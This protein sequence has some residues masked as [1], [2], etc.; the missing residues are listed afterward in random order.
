MPNFEPENL[1]AWSCGKWSHLPQQPIQ[2]FSNDTRTIGQGECFVAIKTDARDGHSFLEQAQQK[3]ASAA[4]VQK[5]NEALDLPQL[6]VGESV[7]AFQ[8]I[9]K[10][11][12][13]GFS[14]SSCRYYWQLRENLNKR[15]SP[16]SFRAG[17]NPCDC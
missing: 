15:S 7:Q 14:R 12:R 16:C 2:G 11:H 9:A 13:K 17:A 3:G 4:I 6:V 1:A 8:Q 10:A 5:Q